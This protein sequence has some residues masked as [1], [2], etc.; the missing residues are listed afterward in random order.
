MQIAMI[1]HIALKRASQP[2]MYC[3][4]KYRTRGSSVCGSSTWVRSIREGTGDIKTT[5]SVVRAAPTPSLLPHEQLHGACFGS[6]GT[7]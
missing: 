4:G 1:V 5:C 3:D 6:I 2:T 7:E